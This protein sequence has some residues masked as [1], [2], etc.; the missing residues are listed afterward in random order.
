M[1]ARQFTRHAMGLRRPSEQD[2]EYHRIPCEKVPSVVYE[3]Q[4]LV[5]C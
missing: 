5:S 3:R 1:S 4:R 2:E